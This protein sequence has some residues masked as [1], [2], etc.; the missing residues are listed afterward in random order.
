MTCT[1]YFIAGA[2]PLFLCPEKM[3]TECGNW[4]IL[5]LFFGIFLCEKAGYNS[6]GGE[7]Q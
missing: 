6:A 2:I 7:K 5:R 3:I 1:G 4:G